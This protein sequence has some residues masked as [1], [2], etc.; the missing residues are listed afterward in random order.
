MYNLVKSLNKSNK[1]SLKYANE[2]LRTQEDMSSKDNLMFLFE[3]LTQVDSRVYDEFVMYKNSFSDYYAQE[4]IDKRVED[5]ANKTVQNAIEF[6]TPALLKEA[7]SKYA[8]LYPQHASTFNT[9]SNLTYAAA[10]KDADVFLKSV[11]EGQFDLSRQKEIINMALTEFEEDE[12][13]IKMAE[14]WAKSV[15]NE[16][17]SAGSYYLLAMT[18]VKQA[19]VSQAIKSLEKCIEKTDPEAKELKLYVEQLQQ[20]KA[21]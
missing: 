10:T 4:F 13:V 11:K 14:K 20:L 15:A 6:K 16:E 7:Q 21:R 3:A 9:N 12:K 1:S 8:Q 18:Q 5:A 19:R 17:E 2:Y